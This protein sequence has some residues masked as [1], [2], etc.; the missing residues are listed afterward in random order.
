MILNLFIFVFFIQQI[1]CEQILQ[2]T[3]VDGDFQIKAKVGTPPIDQILMLQFGQNQD[4]VLG[5]FIF[6]KSIIKYDNQYYTQ[7]LS[8]LTLYDMLKSSTANI[9]SSVIDS[10]GLYDNY[11]GYVSGNTVQDVLEIGNVK[12]NYKFISAIEAPDLHDPYLNGLVTFDRYQDNIFDIMY[13]QKVIKTR[14]YILTSFSSFDQKQTP[15]LNVNFQ[16]DLD[17]YSNNYRYPSNQMNNGKTFQIKAYGIYVNDQDV[18]D[19]I[20]FRIITFDEPFE[21]N[22]VK[23]PMDLFNLIQQDIE[24]LNIIQNGQIPNCPNCQCQQT[25]ILPTFKVISEEYVFEITPNMYTSY[26]LGEEGKYNYCRIRLVGYDN[27]F[28]FSYQLSLYS[29]IPIMYQKASN[30]LRFIGNKTVGHQK[31]EILIPVMSFFSGANLIILIM[32][33]F[34][35]YKKYKFVTREY[36]RD[37]RYIKVE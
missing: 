1:F 36:Y 20:K 10:P 23:I 24:I 30:S 5:Y 12:F 29:K 4:N 32:F 19:N 28:S 17:Q 34:H 25:K 2:A 31:I 18:T 14:D 37:N 6:D 27:S 9:D 3:L 35:I 13:Q 16:Y 7:F 26:L 11:G 21:L 22:Q 15:I 33:A 8:Q